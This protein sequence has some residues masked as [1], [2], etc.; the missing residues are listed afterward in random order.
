V[1][2]ILYGSKVRFL[3]L[4]RWKN[5]EHGSQPENVSHLMRP[6]TGRLHTGVYVDRMFT[7]PVRRQGDQ[8]AVAAVVRGVC[9]CRT[10]RC[11]TLTVSVHAFAY[12]TYFIRHYNIYITMCEAYKSFLSKITPRHSKQAVRSA[13]DRIWG[14]VPPH[15]TTLSY[16]SKYG[17]ENVV[18]SYVCRFYIV[19]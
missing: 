10:V 19:R 17:T 1:R 5:S 8:S 12:R 4:V 13:Y 7:C 15:R 6:I 14:V 11:Q 9:L 16:D 18:C 3:G 2:R